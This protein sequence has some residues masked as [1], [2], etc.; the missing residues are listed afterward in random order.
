MFSFVAFWKRKRM[1]KF[2]F[3]KEFHAKHDKKKI[4]LLIKS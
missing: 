1:L 4:V 2:E 3:R